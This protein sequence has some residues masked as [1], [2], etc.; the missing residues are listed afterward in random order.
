LG[1]INRIGGI[2]IKLKKRKRKGKMS[3]AK[4]KKTA[5]T[6]PT[7]E[8]VCVDKRRLRKPA[9]IYYRIKNI[10]NDAKTAVSD[11]LME[12]YGIRASVDMV[13]SFDKSD[14]CGGGYEQM[15]PTVSI[16]GNPI[17]TVKPCM[18]EGAEDKALNMTDFDKAN[19]L[20]KNIEVIVEYVRE[21]M[22]KLKA[23]RSREKT[24][25]KLKKAMPRLI[26]FDPTIAKYIS[27]LL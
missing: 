27:G 5:K 25:D 10:F 23:E 26:K 22:E 4:G 15:T 7:S 13:E 3:Q 6:V 9:S 11:R 18:V 19:H 20:M 8:K 17:A 21:S 1:L 12:E 16:D 24:V 2:A 14:Y